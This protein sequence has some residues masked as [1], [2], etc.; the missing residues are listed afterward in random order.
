MTGGLAA[1]LALQAVVFVVW[2]VQMFRCLLRLRARAVAQSGKLWPGPVVSLRSFKAFVTEAEYQ[3][4]RRILGG[5]TL[6]MFA[7]IG[8]G[9]LASGQ[10]PR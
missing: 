8:A 2:A 10:G 4:D 3:R 9:A 7:L 1:I 6:L 5:L